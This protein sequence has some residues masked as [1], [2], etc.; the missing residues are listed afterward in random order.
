MVR[1]QQSCERSFPSIQLVSQ[2]QSFVVVSLPE[3][4]AGTGVNSSLNQSALFGACSTRSA[5]ALLS[6]E[7]ATLSPRRSSSSY[8]ISCACP[9]VK[10]AC[11]VLDF[12]VTMDIDHV[13]CN[14]EHIR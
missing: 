6:R 10:Q 8:F 4:R 11:E 12:L 9:R 5:I 2:P 1:H 13:W 3:T 14:Y 7:L